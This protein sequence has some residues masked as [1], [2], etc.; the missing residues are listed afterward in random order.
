M[1][2]VP[3]DVV[4]KAFRSFVVLFGSKV[5]EVFKQKGPCLS[6][7]FYLFCHGA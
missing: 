2:K 5:F 6:D 3:D 1:T 7:N 4:I